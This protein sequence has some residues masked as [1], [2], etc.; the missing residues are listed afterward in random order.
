M[1]NW[2]ID[3]LARQV[4]DLEDRLADY[5]EKN[6]T[7]H[8]RS[9]R[10][11]A[12]TRSLLEI[13]VLVAAGWISAWLAGMWLPKWLAAMIGIAAGLMAAKQLREDYKGAEGSYEANNFPNWRR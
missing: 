9:M 4:K 3:A 12:V 5:A 7:Q 10:M 2:Q 11:H 1:D 6:A 8:R 13:A